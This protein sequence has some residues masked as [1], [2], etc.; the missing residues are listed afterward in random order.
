MS[1]VRRSRTFDYDLYL[2]DGTALTASASGTVDSAAVVLDLGTGFVDADL[3]LDVSALDVAN[4]D[5]IA[6]VEVRL[7][8]TQIATEVYV[9]TQY[10]LG[11]S[12]VVS[13]DV[14]RTTGRYIIPF[15]NIVEDGSCK[16]YMHLYFTL[17][18]TIAAF[19][20]TAYIV[21]K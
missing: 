13:G 6:T 21:K 14:D 8:D 17:A 19:T 1:T 5:E 4:G 2:H 12:A 20:A 3:I 9:A 16:R 11:D 18:G 10:E 7:S 15:N